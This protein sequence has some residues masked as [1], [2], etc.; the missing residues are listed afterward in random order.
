MRP[1]LEENMPTIHTTIGEMTNHIHHTVSTQLVKKL[2]SE[3][4]PEITF[5]DNFY[6]D[7]GYSVVQSY[8]D[9]NHN[10]K[11][12]GTQLNVK[13]YPSLNVQNL[14]WS[15]FSGLHDTSYYCSVARL[16]NHPVIFVDKSAKTFVSELSIPTAITLEFELELRQRDLTY[17]LRD[18][19]FRKYG[20]G[21][22]HTE[23]IEYTYPL[24]QNVIL[25]LYHIFKLRKFNS[26][27]TF[28]EYLQKGSNELIEKVVSKADLSGEKD[29]ELVVPKQLANVHVEVEGNIDRPEE[30]KIDKATTSYTLNFTLSAQYTRAD[31]LIMKY[32]VVVD[33]QVIP[34]SLTPVP[35]SAHTPKMADPDYPEYG[36]SFETVRRA[37]LCGGLP[38]SIKIPYYDDWIRPESPLE[39]SSYREFAS[40]VFTLDGPTTTLDLSE[41]SVKEDQEYTIHPIILETLT[42]FQRAVFRVDSLLGLEIYADDDLIDPSVI[43]LNGTQ[44]TLNY[45]DPKCE[46]RLVLYEMEKIGYLDPEFYPWVKEHWPFFRVSRDISRLVKLKVINA[47]PDKIFDDP[48]NQFLGGNLDMLRRLKSLFADIVT[49]RER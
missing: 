32:P 8:V 16:N 48:S 49:K 27:I 14:K 15:S 28:E 18:R 46:Y 42:K 25:A 39:S 47:H 1:Y 41:F 37:F 38:S 21:H 3:I 9:H 6:L 33:N 19:L 35:S 12:K 30:N 24:P 29:V 31:M 23:I 2:T 20:N 4:F 17:A 22:V 7:T 44:I 26:P 40:I 5:H 43:Q 36:S 34:S 11:L 45:Y 10:H 13:A